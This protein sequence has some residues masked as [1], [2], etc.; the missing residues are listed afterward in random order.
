MSQKYN[1]LVSKICE[2]IFCVHLSHLSFSTT[3]VG[4]FTFLPWS[5]LHGTRKKKLIDWFDS[6]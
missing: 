3:S 5:L 2:R 4:S 6:V 1:K